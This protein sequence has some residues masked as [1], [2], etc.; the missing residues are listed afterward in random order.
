MRLAS[1]SAGLISIMYQSGLGL[2][3]CPPDEKFFEEYKLCIILVCTS[4]VELKD[5]VVVDVGVVDL[6][7]SCNVGNGVFVADMLECAHQKFL[8]SLY[9][10]ILKSGP[11]KIVSKPT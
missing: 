9:A 4:V 5:L 11:P 8:R 1:H 2:A 3:F 6:M 10:L 7:D